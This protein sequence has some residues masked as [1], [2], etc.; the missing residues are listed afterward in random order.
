MGSGLSQIPSDWRGE[1][2]GPASTAKREGF[3]EAPITRRGAER[4][5][6]A[7]VLTSASING[8]PHSQVISPCCIPHL[9][10]RRGQWT[11]QSGLSATGLWV[12]SARRA[13]AN[14]A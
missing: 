8:K 14:L 3:A 13:A 10:L 5:R 11:T 7:G 9:P 12:M 1:G 4:G 6:A 2:C